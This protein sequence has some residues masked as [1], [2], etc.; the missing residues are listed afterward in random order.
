MKD[1]I[2]FYLD[3]NV[4]DYLIKDKLKVVSELFNQLENPQI[5]Y[6]YVTLREFSRIENESQRNIFLDYLK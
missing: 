3:Q 1:S 5:I 6:S 2:K 4:I